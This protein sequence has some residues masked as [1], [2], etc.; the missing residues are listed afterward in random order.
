MNNTS[1]GRMATYLAKDQDN[2]FK[3]LPSPLSLV[4]CKCQNIQFKIGICRLKVTTE[5]SGN[6]FRKLVIWLFKLLQGQG[7]VELPLFN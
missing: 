4:H 2:W 7:N 3:L 5:K 6:I 1:L